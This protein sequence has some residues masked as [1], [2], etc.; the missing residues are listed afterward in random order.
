MGGGVGEGEGEGDGG[1]K[2]VHTD[3]VPL[4]CQSPVACF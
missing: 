4:S 1:L 3:T 2:P